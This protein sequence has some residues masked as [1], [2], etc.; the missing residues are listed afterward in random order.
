M[1]VHCTLQALKLVQLRL[2]PHEDVQNQVLLVLQRSGG[3][4][5]FRHLLVVGWW[6]DGVGVVVGTCWDGGRE[7][8]WDGAR[9]VVRWSLGWWW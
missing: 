1:Q 4:Y 5:T 9:M 7:G 6:W 2:S 8:P 3:T